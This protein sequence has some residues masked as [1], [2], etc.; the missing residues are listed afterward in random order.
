MRNSMRWVA[1]VSVALMVVSAATAQ[2]PQRGQR[3]GGGFGNRTT[4]QFLLA[5][6]D[7]QKELKLTDEQKDKVKAFAP[8][9]GQGGRGGAGGGGRQR[10]QGG[11]GGGQ[12]SEQAQAAEK[13]VKE[14]LTADQQKRFKQIRVQVMG[15]PA[16]A[17]ED[18]QTALKF[19]DDQKTKIKT[20]VDDYNKDVRELMPQRGQGG[21]GGGGNANFQEIAQKREALTKTY[22]EK[23][24][25]VLT[26]DQKTA[27][28]DYIGAEFK[29][30]ARRP[31]VDR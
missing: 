25:A 11:Q 10:G 21:G 31:P 16:F 4:P 2:P 7:V 20:L 23:A 5:N 6:E 19:T 27:W 17:D 3:G 26:A 18:V 13:F 24:Q 15:V 12:N 30:Q 1:A 14:S 28:K 29:L 9:Q 22:T 8:A